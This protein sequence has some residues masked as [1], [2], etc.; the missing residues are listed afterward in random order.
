VGELVV[1]RLDAV[2]AASE[3]RLEP[4]VSGTCAGFSDANY[5]AW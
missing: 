5:R 4:I 3:V 1:G 2:R